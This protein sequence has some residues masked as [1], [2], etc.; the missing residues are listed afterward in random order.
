MIKFYLAFSCLSTKVFVCNLLPQVVETV[1]NS[2]DHKIDNA[3][4]SLNALCLGDGSVSLE[5]V[6]L[7]LKSSALEG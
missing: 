2:H 7:I 6:N 3:I 1:L 4:K 5:E